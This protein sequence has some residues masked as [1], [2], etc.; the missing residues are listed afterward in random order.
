LAQAL[1]RLREDDAG[2]LEEFSAYQRSAAPFFERVEVA[3]EFLELLTFKIKESRSRMDK[4]ALTRFALDFFRETLKPYGY[5]PKFVAVQCKALAVYH[6]N[7]KNLDRAIE[8]CEFLIRNGI[9]DD[10]AKGFHVRLDELY[11]LRR[12]LEEKGGDLSAVHIPVVD[13][14]EEDEEMPSSP[15]LSP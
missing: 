1:R 2:I 13:E 10:D 15:P 8:V 9:T 12:K 3:H 11:R 14:E 7:Q 6:Q 5:N 4:D